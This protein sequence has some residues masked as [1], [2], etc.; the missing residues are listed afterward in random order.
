MKNIKRRWWLLTGLLVALVLTGC[1]VEPDDEFPLQ[2]VSEY[3]N[4]GQNGKGSS[5]DYRGTYEGVWLKE[6]TDEVV[7]EAVLTVTDKLAFS[8]IPLTDGLVWNNAVLDFDLRGY[9]YNA[10][11]ND[12]ELSEIEYSGDQ[13]PCWVE[14][15]GL[16]SSAVFDTTT[17][18]T[19]VL[20]MKVTD[21]ETPLWLTFVT[22]RKR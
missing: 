18:W 11:Y 17:K 15:D 12:L 2:D 1:T 9:S 6:N 20:M 7:A 19:C 10:L 4:F 13:P 8:V 14:I 21:S 16:T 22:R 3:A 5:K